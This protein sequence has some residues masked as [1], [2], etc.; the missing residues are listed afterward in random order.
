MVVGIDFKCTFTDIVNELTK[1]FVEI[2]QLL[3]IKSEC[4]IYF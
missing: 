3:V 2:K 4:L 1:E